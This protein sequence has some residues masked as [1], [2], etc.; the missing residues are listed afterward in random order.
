MERGGI[1]K[2]EIQKMKSTPIKILHLISLPTIAPI[3]S[4]KEIDNELLKLAYKEVQDLK[5]YI[6]WI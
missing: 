4:N 1:T 5:K 3:I 2:D 6:I